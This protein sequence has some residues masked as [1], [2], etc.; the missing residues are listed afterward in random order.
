[1]DNRYIR[2]F[3]EPFSIDEA[4]LDVTGCRK[5]FGPPED[6]ALHLKERIRREVGVR[7]SVGIGPNKLLAKIAAELEKPDGLTLLDYGDVREKL[8]PL[9]VRKLF[10]VGPRYEQHLRRFN[11]RTIGDRGEVSRRYFETPLRGGWRGS[12]AMRQR[13]RSQPG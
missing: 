5:L 1:M 13:H 6:I 7:C 12:P 8:W 11:I 2:H 3:M 9:P 4:F 10:G